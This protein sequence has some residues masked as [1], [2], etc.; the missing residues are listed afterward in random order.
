MQ[1]TPIRWLALVLVWLLNAP[2]TAAEIWVSPNGSDRNPGT[3]EAPLQTLHAA[4]RQARELR[5]LHDPT[6]DGGIFVNMQGGIYPLAEMLLVRPEDSGTAESPTVIR[7]VAG[8][9]PVLSAGIPVRNWTPSKGNISGL[10]AVARDKVWEAPLPY[11]GN[12]PAEFRQ[13]WVEGEKAVRARSAEPDNMERMVSFDMDGRRIRIPAPDAPASWG[14]A[15]QLEMMA[16]QRWAVAFLRV[17]AVETLHGQARLTFHDPESR[18]E[19]EHPWP[20]PVI[21]G[22]RGN[23]AFV[24]TNAIEFL[25]T[26]GEWYTDLKTEKIYYWPRSGEDMRTASA[27]VP[28]LETL[29]E[30]A[31]TASRPVS[32]VRFEGIGFEHAGWTRP[33]QQGHVPL[34][35]GMYIIDA[36]KLAVPG[37]PGKP[38]LENQAWIGR[39][40]AAVKAGGAEHISFEKCTFRRLA[41]TGLDLERAVKNVSVAGCD[42]TDVGGTALLAGAFPDRGYETHVGWTPEFEGEIC[43]NVVI[44][45]NIVKNVANEDWGCVGIGVG[46]ARDFTIDHNEVAG[47]PYSGIS[48]GWGWLSTVNVSGG[49]RITANYVHDFAR[50]LYD[51]GGI[52]TLS[53]QPGTV[54][55]RNRIEAIGAA[56]YATNDRAFYIYF[57][58]ASAYL[59]VRDNWMPEEH[60]GWNQPGMN[61]LEN[62]GPGVGPAIRA[63]AG[64]TR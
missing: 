57:D 11:V 29:V 55:E 14:T 12:R 42:F 48:V 6:I 25:D 19:F 1:K 43:S 28:V 22:E 44:S 59:D 37:L 41:S 5:R 36:Y 45:N 34:Q 39:P 63:A 54:I 62:N 20:Q 47:V 23:S 24:L 16:M 51:A 3:K 53:A 18:I 38:G 4:L 27:I 13:M 35:T 10:P 30:F 40:E 33:S 32:H 7:A 64:V 9:N 15:P 60:Y 58:E 49:H 52:Y 50:Q 21:D 46:Y 17:K 61:R 56:P 8:E 31:G 26:P 2:L